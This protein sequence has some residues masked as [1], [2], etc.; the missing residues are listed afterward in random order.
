VIGVQYVITTFVF[1]LI[2]GLLAMVM[3]AELASPG[4]QVVTDEQYNGIMS[5]HAVLMIFLFIIPIFAGLGNYVIPL[6]LGAPDMAF[7]RLNAVSFWILPLAGLTFLSAF[8]VG[9]Y[10]TGW[11]AYPTLALESPLGQ[12]VFEVGVQLAGA[13]SIA[14]ALNFLVTIIAMRAPGMTAFRMPLLV[15]A[16]LTTS[17]LIVVATPFIAGSQFMTMFDR[18]AGMN[19]FRPEDGGSL[20]SYQ[21]IFWFYSHPAVYIMILPGFGS[22]P[23]S[24]PPTAASRSSATARSPSRRSASRSSASRSGRTTCSCPAWSRGCGCR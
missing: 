21:H 23:R 18:V 7:P 20:I 4:E 11:T 1:F 2:G 24:S 17:A 6:M 19:F 3:R 10:D 8:L 16:N 13:S 9:S 22:S 12:T 15:W 14:A 5:Q